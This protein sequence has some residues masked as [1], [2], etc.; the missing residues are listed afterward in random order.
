MS[1]MENQKLSY[2]QALRKLQVMV[3]EY[4]LN[5]YKVEWTTKSFDAVDEEYYRE[6]FA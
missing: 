6:L 3:D 4:E 5:G 1:L 2:H